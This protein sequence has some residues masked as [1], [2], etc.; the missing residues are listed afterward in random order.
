MGGW[1]LYVFFIRDKII[2]IGLYNIVKRRKVVYGICW[3][4]KK[5]KLCVNNCLC[6]FKLFFNLNI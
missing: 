6:I 5:K 2:I 3:N 4:I 1:V